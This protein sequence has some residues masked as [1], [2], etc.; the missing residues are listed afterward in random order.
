MEINRSIETVHSL[1]CQIVTMPERVVPSKKVFHA[2]Y[3]SIIYFCFS[4]K[5]F[6]II[7]FLS[8]RRL[9]VFFTQTMEPVFWLLVQE[10][11]RSCGNGPLMKWILLERWILHNNACILLCQKHC[12]VFCLFKRRRQVLFLHTGHRLM[13]FVWLMSS[14]TL[15]IRQ[16]HVWT[17]QRM[18]T[19]LLRHMEEKLH[20]STW[21]LFGWVFNIYDNMLYFISSF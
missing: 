3:D 14:R 2:N 20:C 1:Q 4:V 16:L 6:M 9:F 7:N 10:G 5:N 12:W 11:V 18:I 17:S 19:M 8:L 15:V 13:V 21:C